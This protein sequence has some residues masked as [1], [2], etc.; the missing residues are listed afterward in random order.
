MFARVVQPRSSGSRGTIAHF[1]GV[2]SE[3]PRDV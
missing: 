3:N 2:L 1:R